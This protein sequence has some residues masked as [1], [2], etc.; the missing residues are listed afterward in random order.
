MSGAAGRP[1]GSSGA[2]DQRSGREPESASFAAVRVG[3]RRG[4]PPAFILGFVAVLVA[5]VAV[6]VGGRTPASP[7]FA[8]V[9]LDSPSAVPIVATA[10][11]TPSGFA[12][13]PAPFVTSGPGQIEL[14][15]RRRPESVFVH[16]DVFVARVTWVYVSLRDDAGRV[17]GWASVSVPGRAGP[18]V[19]SGPT[20][21]FDVELAVP[22]GFSGRLWI[23][24]NAYDDSGVLIGSTR[25]GVGP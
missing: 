11:P 8:P 23:V 5:V 22:E 19:G 25:I 14:Q 10:E 1:G 24:A 7:T 21:R 17:A 4:W 3:G 15:A 9:A 16:G 2:P 20:L 12:H 13:G 18:G 6:G